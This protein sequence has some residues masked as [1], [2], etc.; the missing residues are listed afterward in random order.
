MAGRRN[1]RAVSIFSTTGDRAPARNRIVPSARRRIIGVVATSI[2]FS[3]GLDSK[4]WRDAVR[5]LFV[6]LRLVRRPDLVGR[7]IDRHPTPEELPEGKLVMV[8][9]G[10]RNKWACLRC[11]GR[12][13]EKL[14][15]ALSSSRHPRWCVRLDWLGRPSVSPSIRQLNDCRCHFWI[16]GGTVHWCADSGQH[17]PDSTPQYSC[18]H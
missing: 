5:W 15:L 7:I 10:N 16:E 17:Q 1:A 11:P 8:R 6:R 4:M 9:D 14:Q 12:C 2:H 3:I 13:G 18:S